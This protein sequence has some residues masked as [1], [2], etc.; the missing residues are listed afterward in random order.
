MITH[1]DQ[2]KHTIQQTSDWLHLE[3]KP[4]K[5]AITSGASCPDAVV[6]SVILRIVSWF[7]HCKSPTEVMSSFQPFIE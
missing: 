2:W 7:E 5:I 4:L 1:F 3:R 6:D